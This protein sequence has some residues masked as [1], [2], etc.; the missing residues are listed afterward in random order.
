MV[1]NFGSGDFR[2]GDTTLGKESI[3][4]A[5]RDGGKTQVYSAQ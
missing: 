4:V 5:R 2:Y 1:A 3:L